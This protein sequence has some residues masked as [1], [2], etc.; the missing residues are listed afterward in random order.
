MDVSAAANNAYGQMHMN[1]GQGN[2]MK[3]VMQGL[4]NDD[5]A[6]VRDQMQSLPR[7]ER[8]AMKEQMKAL[9]SSNLSSDEYFQSLLD[10]FSQTDTVEADTGFSVYA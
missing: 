10:M 3:D 7:E 1:Q 5:R 6:V 2:G 4:S 8:L 9:D